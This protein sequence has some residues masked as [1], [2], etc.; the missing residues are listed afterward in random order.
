MRTTITA[1]GFILAAA[2][3]AALLASMTNPGISQQGALLAAAVG[4]AL[5]FGGANA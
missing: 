2:G 5:Y 1:I 3:I 4:A